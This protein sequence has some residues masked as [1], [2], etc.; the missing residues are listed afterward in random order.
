MSSGPAQFIV[1]DGSIVAGA[2]SYVTVEW[3]TSYLS[4]NSFAYT[5]WQNLTLSQQQLLL[6]WATRYLDA[7][8][9]W[10]GEMTSV[11]DNGPENGNGV[12]AGWA[13]VTDDEE[14]PTQPLRFPRHGTYD[15]DGNPLPDDQ[16][17]PQL[18]AATAE[19]AR[20]LIAQD[21]SIERP[22]DG[23]KEL[24]IDVMTLIFKADYI[25]PVVPEQITYIIRGLGTI[26]S[27]MTG[28]GK[29]RRA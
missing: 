21:R 7:R 2:T 10:N 25:L 6:C 9:T 22:Q 15:Y 1:E 26:A 27:G 14:F 4:M 13:N 12:I 28:F 24:K 8:A 3:A 29:I 17:P 16:I 11:Y 20:Y 23:L 19:M 5:A 18:M